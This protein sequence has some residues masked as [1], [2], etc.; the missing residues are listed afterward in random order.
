MSVRVNDVIGVAGYVLPGTHVDVLA[1]ASPTDARRHDDEV[2]LTNV[3]VLAAGT[4]M[5]Q[6]R[7]RAS[8]WRSRRDAARLPE[9][10]ERL[11]LGATQ[12]RFSSRF[13]TRSTR[14]PRHAW[15][16]PAGLLGLSASRS[17]LARRGHARPP[18]RTSGNADRGPDAGAYRRDDS[19]R[20]AQSEVIR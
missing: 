5:E 3:Q 11:T 19:W 4:K 15:H 16:Q 17:P 1:T 14:D 10:S 9:Q 6:D 13:A 2:V 7:S 8:P 20:Q 18:S 12:A